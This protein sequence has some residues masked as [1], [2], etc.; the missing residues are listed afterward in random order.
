[1]IALTKKRNAC[2]LER[3]HKFGIELPKT[4]KEALALDKKND[5]IYWIDVITKEMKNVRPVF[6]VMEDGE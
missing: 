3:T 6:K 4:A 1:M 2:Y 5:N